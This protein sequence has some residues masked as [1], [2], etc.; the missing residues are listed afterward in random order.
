MI[1]KPTRYTEKFVLQEVQSM[2]IEIK[3]NADV[4]FLGQVFEERDYSMQRFSEWREK[5]KDN[6][7][8]SEAMKR[9]QE[10]L[11]TRVVVGTMK[12][13]LNPTIVIFHLKNNYQWTDKVEESR[14]KE[15][16]KPIFV[17]WMLDNP[18]AQNSPQ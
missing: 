12:K 3:N 6:E 2:L 15:L 18:Q 14:N 11:E 10:L 17:S 16:P 7:E 9:I 8:I 4:F 5:F 13:E 1:T